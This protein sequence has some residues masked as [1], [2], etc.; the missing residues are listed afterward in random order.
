MISK[1]NH[2]ELN[3]VDLKAPSKEELEHIFEEYPVPLN[4]KEKI[5]TK[6]KEDQTEI[7]Y[8][9]IYVSIG[10]RMIFIACDRFVLSIHSESTPAFDPFSNELELDI[11]NKEEINNNKILFAHL[12]KNLFKY[13]EKELTA[14]DSQ[15]KKLKIKIDKYKKT[16]KKLTTFILLLLIIIFI[17]AT[18]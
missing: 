13:N 3:W 14:N 16:I 7:N 1:Y 17:I 15:I 9:F 11:V 12:L 5:L 6:N 10:G 2:K 18:I 8:D 4:I